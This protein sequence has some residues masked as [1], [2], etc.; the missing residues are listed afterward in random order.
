MHSQLVTPHISKSSCSF[1]SLALIVTIGAEK[2]SIEC[3]DAPIRLTMYFVLSSRYDA[4]FILHL[5]LH[6]PSGIS[7]LV[8]GT[9]RNELTMLD[10]RPSNFISVIHPL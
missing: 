5:N 7:L 1:E 3:N 2:L 4:R 8:L 6:G 10:G 9:F